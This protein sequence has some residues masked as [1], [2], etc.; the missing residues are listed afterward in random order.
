MDLWCL[1]NIINKIW[2]VGLFYRRMLEFHSPQKWL[3]VISE[4][5]FNW[6]CG[7]REILLK[8]DCMGIEIL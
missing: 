4:K 8:L 1:F 2:L 5:L 3:L 6:D 7:A